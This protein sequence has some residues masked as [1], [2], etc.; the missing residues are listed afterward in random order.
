[1]KEECYRIRIYKKPFP[2]TMQGEEHCKY[3][4]YWEEIF[5]DDTGKAY[6][7]VHKINAY[8]SLEDMEADF[9]GFLC[10]MEYMDEMD[11]DAEVDYDKTDL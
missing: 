3:K 2:V 11:L 7:R 1:M 6:A 9:E 10:F 5:R 4:V 8:H